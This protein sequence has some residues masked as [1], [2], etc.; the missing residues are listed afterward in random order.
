M[1]FAADAKLAV[2]L[3]EFHQDAGFMVGVG[4]GHDG[5]VDGDFPAVRCLQAYLAL[6]EG[7]AQHRGLFKAGVQ[8]VAGA[9]HEVAGLLSYQIACAGGEQH[10]SRGIDITQAQI[11][12]EQDD[13]G[14]QVVQDPRREGLR[15]QVIGIH[16][17]YS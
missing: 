4:Q 2:E 8:I 13:G 1:L 17:K 14:V 5:A 16:A 11:L 6:G 3:L 12:V 15:E 7:M 9:A 10:L